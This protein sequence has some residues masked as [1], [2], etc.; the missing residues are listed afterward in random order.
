[1]VQL[2]HVPIL[3][4]VFVFHSDCAKRVKTE[5]AIRASPLTSLTHLHIIEE[6]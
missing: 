2:D 5:L 1:M 3:D 6:T 4:A